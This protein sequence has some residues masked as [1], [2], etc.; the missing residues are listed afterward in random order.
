MLRQRE[1]CRVIEA[2]TPF[3][4]VRGMPPVCKLQ[5]ARVNARMD[6]TH[7]ASAYVPAARSVDARVD[8]R[9]NHDTAGVRLQADVGQHVVPAQPTSERLWIARLAEHVEETVF[10]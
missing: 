2:V 7:I 4:R 1:G 9:M 10:R 3:E 5:R 6:A 8:Q